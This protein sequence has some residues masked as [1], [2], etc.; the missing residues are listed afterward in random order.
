M[1]KLSLL[2]AI[3]TVV[4][5]SFFSLQA[6]DQINYQKP[7]EAITKILDA[8]K[9]PLTLLSPDKTKM[10]ILNR[11]GLPDIKELSG[12]ELKLAGLRIDPATN[13][14][15]RSY[16]YD[17]IQILFFNSKEIKPIQNLPE[18]LNIQN[19][20]WSPDSEKIALTLTRENGIELWVITINNLTAYALSKPVINDAIGFPYQWKTN[21]KGLIYKRCLQNRGA[22]PEKPKI[23]HG[24]IVQDN[25]GETA[26]VRTYQDLLKNEYDA[27]LFEFFCS[28]EIFISDLKNQNKSTGIKG[29]IKSFAVA[30]GN[31]FIMVETIKKPFSYLVPYYRF[32]FDVK[33]WN[34]NGTMVK[35]IA[36]IPIA[37]NIPKGFGAVRTGPRNF[38]WRNDVP[39]TVFWTKALDEGDPKNEAKFRDQIYF[40]KAPFKGEPQKSLTLELRYGGIDWGKNDF[41]IAYEWWWATRKRITSSFNPSDVN[42]QKTVI[43]DRSWENQYEDPGQFLQQINPQ[44]KYVLAFDNQRRQLYLTGKGASPEGNKPFLDAFNIENHDIQRLWQ[45]KPP[46]YSYPYGFIDQK[47]GSILIKKESKTE[48]PNFF[49]LNYKTNELDTL[50]N[51]PHPYPELRDIQMNLIRYTRADGIQLTGK[52]YLPVGYDP[53]K[54]KLPLIIWAYPNEYKSANAASQV[55]DSPYQFTRLGWWSPLLWL[56]QGYAVLDDASMPVIGEGDAEPNDSF[57]SQ[58]V[59]NAKAAID[60]LSEINLIDPDKVAVGGHSYGAFMTANLLAHSDLFAAGIARSGA[61]NRT[62]TPFGFQAEERT[63]W[64]AKEVYM[65]MSP[66]TY[67]DQIKTPLL[68]IHGEEDNNSGTFPMQSERF[69]EALKGH[70]A[71]ARLVILPKE[72]HGYK[73]R[74]SILHMAWEM[75]QWL[76]KYVKD[77]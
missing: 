22:I 23:P 5:L 49:I 77:K 30:P 50:T 37:E 71:I 65:K 75:D 59:S 63:F 64:E 62:L 43:F 56:T 72:S 73:A 55:K 3:S 31:E 69:F 25:A 12:E 4:M 67:A 44:G 70:G 24:P 11:P 60:T 27:Q 47:E 68:L 9:A 32:P 33:I 20:S 74:Q 10:I 45:S 48:Y 39:A 57:I 66:F 21:S 36:D 2:L 34:F 8:P 16:Y 19:V 7:P 52:L 13:G 51:Y 6:Q 53:E 58:L 1:K 28:S 26:A 14:S 61:Y 38:Q 29:I 35:Q 42:A 15:S 54:G 18:E 41:A 40:L 46:Y 17:G 76:K